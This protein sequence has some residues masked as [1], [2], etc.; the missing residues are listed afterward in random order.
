MEVEAV[1]RVLMVTEG[2][3]IKGAHSTPFLLEIKACKKPPNAFQRTKNFHPQKLWITLWAIRLQVS[4]ALV[5]SG[6]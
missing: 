2:F 4:P 6:L 1:E 5:V 3:G